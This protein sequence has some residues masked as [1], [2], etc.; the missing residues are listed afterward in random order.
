MLAMKSVDS[1]DEV[2]KSEECLE[3]L[4]CVVERTVDYAVPHT[5]V[6]HRCVVIRKVSPTP[7]QYPR[8]FA[9]IQK[10]PL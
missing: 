1:G 5:D 6:T 3:K 7:K 10:E 8:R 9:K 2:K 4:G